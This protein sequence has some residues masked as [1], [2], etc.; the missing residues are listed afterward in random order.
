MKLRNLFAICFFISL[1]SAY[2]QKPEYAAFL[3][4]QELKENANAVIRSSECTL[5]ILSQDKMEYLERTVTTV[6]NEQGLHDLDLAENYDQT[7][8]IAKIEARTYDALGNE[9]RVYKRKD[10]RDVSVGDGFS[11]FND[12]R[13]LYLDYTPIGYPFTVVFEREI[14]TSNTAFIRN[15]SPLPSYY[16]STEKDVVTVNYPV[17]LGFSYKEFNFSDKFKIDKKETPGS[18]SYT[19]SNIHALKGEETS[20]EWTQIVPTIYFKVEKFSLEGIDGQ[21]ATWKDFGKWYFDNL[22]TG[23]DVL[24]IETQNTIRNLVGS[25]KDPVKIARIVYKYVQEKT[26]YVSIQVGIGGFKPMLASD[27]DKLGYGD[28]KALTNYTRSLLETVGITSYFTLVNA[29]DYTQ[30]NLHTD[31]VSMQGNHA[32]LT[33]PVGDSYIWLECTSQISPFGFQGPFTDGRDVL[34]VKPDGGEIVKTRPLLEKDNSQLTTGTYRISA[35]GLISGKL[36]IVT[37]GSQYAKTFAK[38]RYS[39]KDKEDYYKNYFGNI[40]SLKLEHIDFKNDA[41][42]IQFTQNIA[43]SAPAYASIN[44]DRLMFALNAFNQSNNTPKHYRSRENPFQVNR[45]YYDEDEIAIDLPEGFEIEALPA[46]FELNTKYGDYQMHIEKKSA[47][48][49]LYKRTLLIKNG[50]YPNTE[51]EAYRQFREQVA[52]SDNAKVVLTRKS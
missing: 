44:S 6:F 35:E 24:P 11:V 43:L 42:N 37:T 5:N 33:L 29:D 26:R 18:I 39:E 22:L 19:A 20:P 40:N 12:D 52:K 14:H 2:A 34:L 23:T 8:K 10:F 9:I 17:A 47:T 31:I 36:S 16:V 51:Y 45:G 46:D 48:S 28:C 38:A 50:F 30:K 21:A 41:D 49:L 4:P 32:I 13:M 1:F 15:W 3:I 27:V 25:E 7:T